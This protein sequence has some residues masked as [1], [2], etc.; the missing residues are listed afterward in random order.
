[1]IN[2]F[3]YLLTLTLLT[4]GASSCAMGPTKQEVAPPMAQV[5]QEE[6]NSE[7]VE[8]ITDKSYEE[9]KSELIKELKKVIKKEII[10]EIQSLSGVPQSVLKKQRKAKLSLKNKIVIGRIENIEIDGTGFALKARVDTGAKTCSIHAENIVE[11]MVDGKE[12]IQFVS[13]NTENKKQVF[14]KEVVKDQKV[15]SSNGEVSTRYVVKMSIQLGTKIHNVNVNLNDREDLRYNFLIG[16]NLLMGEYV[17]DVSQT[18]LLG[19]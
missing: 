14:L 15:K 4:L 16:R 3:C 6:E 18:R 17:V 8:K 19:Q 7:Q 2:L 5:T 12:Y 10:P 11:K 13:E 9:V 1:M